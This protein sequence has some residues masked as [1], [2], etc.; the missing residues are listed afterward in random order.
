[1]EALRDA[2]IVM[3]HFYQFIPTIL[4][5]E[6]MAANAVLMASADPGIETELPPG[7]RDAWVVTPYWRVYHNLKALL[8]DP[9]NLQNQAD[10]GTA[11][12]AQNCTRSVDRARLLTLL[13]AAE[14]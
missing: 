3:N 7:A 8:D 6:A 5:L 12:V 11:W 2:H 10:R 9:T 14:T 1:L 4:G 13:S